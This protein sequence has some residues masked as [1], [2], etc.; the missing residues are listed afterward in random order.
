MNFSVLEK[1]FVPVDLKV[2]KYLA[3]ND[4]ANSMNSVKILLLY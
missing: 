1:I 3:D 2:N 4:K